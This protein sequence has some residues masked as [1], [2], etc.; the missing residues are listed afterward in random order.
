MAKSLVSCFFDSRCIS[1]FFVFSNKI[2][3]GNFVKRHSRKLFWFEITKMLIAVF[4][5]KFIV[6]FIII[7][8]TLSFPARRSA[9]SSRPSGPSPMSVFV[10][11]PSRRSSQ[12]APRLCVCVCGA[13][14]TLPTP[15]YKSRRYGFPLGYSLHRCAAGRSPSGYVRRPQPP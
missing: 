6:S 7:F 2:H 3:G 5:N 8:S 12:P 1:I 10:A 4:R 9:A 13:R 14:S 15:S 11:R